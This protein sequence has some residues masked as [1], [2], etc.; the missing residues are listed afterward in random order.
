MFELPV[1]AESCELPNLILNQSSCIAGLCACLRQIIKLASQSNVQHW[2]HNLLGFKDSCLLACAETSTWTKFCEIDLISTLKQFTK[3]PYTSELPPNIVRFEAHMAQPVRLH[4]IKKYTTSKK[5]IL[6]NLILKDECN[7]TLEHCYAEGSFMTLADLII[8]ICFHI[9]FM[10]LEK[11]KLFKLLPLTG[12]WYNRI[13]ETERIEKCLNIFPREIKN[14]SATDYLPPILSDHQSLY[15]SDAKRY[16]PKSKWFTKQEDVEKSLELSRKI[17][18]NSKFTSVTDLNDFQIDWNKIPAEATPEGGLLPLKRLQKKFH[19]LENLCKPVIKLASPGDVIVD[20]CSGSGHLGILV[21]Y[22]LPQCTIV[23]LENKEISLNRSKERVKKLKMTN[24]KFFQCNID[25]F[26]GS[27]NIGMSLH[28]CGVATDLVIQHCL[29]QSAIFV[30]CP[31]CYGS[32]QDCH[33][34][35]YPRSNI[36]KSKINLRDYLILCHAADQTHDEKNIKTKQGYDCMFIIDTD[37]KLQAEQYNY[38]VYLTKLTPETCT[39]KNHLLI[40]VPKNKS[41]NIY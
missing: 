4:N 31:C 27:F 28:A 16:K 17:I 39:P 38:T 32:I 41:V 3:D 25:Y 37:R 35:T 12:K 15:K 18:I 21:A 5:F 9:L 23:L 30:S 20:F 22:L 8:F 13:R 19:Q 10:F 36:F 24:I 2:C 33:H 40:G 11:E 34:I 14:I 26:K 7:S 1:N 29:R 6:E